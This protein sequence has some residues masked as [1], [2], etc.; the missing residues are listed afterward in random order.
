LS[1]SLYHLIV[2][3]DKIKKLVGYIRLQRKS[4]VSVS[5]FVGFVLGFFEISISTDHRLEGR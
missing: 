1:K 3:R 2:R 4:F 5:I